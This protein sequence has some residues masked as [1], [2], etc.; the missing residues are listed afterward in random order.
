MEAIAVEVS[1]NKLGAFVGHG[2]A[3]KKCPAPGRKKSNGETL[4][5]W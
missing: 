5:L 3:F 1:G 2:S 4:P